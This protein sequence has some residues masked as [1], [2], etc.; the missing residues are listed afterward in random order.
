MRALGEEF[1]MNG[2]IASSLLGPY[3]SVFT[4]GD[5]A[6]STQIGT[7]KIEICKDSSGAPDGAWASRNVT[8]E[9]RFNS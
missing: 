5:T 2:R 8:L 7:F 1:Q 6:P 4:Y 3:V 9:A